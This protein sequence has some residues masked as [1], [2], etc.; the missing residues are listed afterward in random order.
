MQEG[1]PAPVIMND[2]GQKIGK[3]E[4]E[5]AILMRENDNYKKEN[6]RL[7]GENAALNARLA[8]FE[9]TFEDEALE[10]EIESAV[11]GD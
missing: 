7:Q 11:T 9:Q 10:G 1:I 4:V 5:K 6:E 2:L 8:H 3:L